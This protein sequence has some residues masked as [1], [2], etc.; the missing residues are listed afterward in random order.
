MGSICKQPLDN[1][2][3]ICGEPSESEKGGLIIGSKLICFVCENRIINTPIEDEFY[4][5]FKEQ[6]K[7]VWYD[8]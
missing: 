6:L 2:C 3:I 1:I 5:T 7:R 8:S 4:S